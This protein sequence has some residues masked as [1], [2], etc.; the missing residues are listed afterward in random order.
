M[1]PFVVKPRSHT[2]PG[3][4]TAPRRDGLRSLPKRLLRPRFFCRPPSSPLCFFTLFSTFLRPPHPP[5]SSFHRSS[6]FSP[7]FLSSPARL[8]PSIL[9]LFFP[10][11]TPLSSPGP[12][13]V[14][15]SAVRPVVLSVP[16]A[17]R[18]AWHRPPAP[19]SRNAKPVD[20]RVVRVAGRL[21]RRLL[22]RLADRAQPASANFH[23]INSRSIRMLH[24]DA[25]RAINR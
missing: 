5:L 18:P 15:P 4:T 8:L 7:P 1:F 13:G 6:L 20:L 12:A 9:F 16:R 21:L 25:M 14:C 2:V 17:W 19:A 22:K 10:S 11:T 24:N 23:T 3:S